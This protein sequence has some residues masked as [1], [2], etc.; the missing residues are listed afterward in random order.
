MMRLFVLLLMLL[1]PAG[2]FADNFPVTNKKVSMAYVKKIRK[3][4][5][6]APKMKKLRESSS[7]SDHM[8]CMDKMYAFK[9]KIAKLEQEGESLPM[10]SANLSFRSAA[11][12]LKLCL[13]CSDLADSNCPIIEMHIK[14]GFK[15]LR[16]E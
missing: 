7:P 6:E 5:S 12:Q 8:A 15:Y 13:I 2:S 1:I 9:P 4:Y 16:E 11:G 3:L 14:D 10:T